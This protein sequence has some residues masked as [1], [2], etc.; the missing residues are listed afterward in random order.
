[1]KPLLALTVGD[2]AGVG[3]EIV[4]KALAEPEAREL[5]RYL[6][7]GP[8]QVVAAVHERLRSP[9][10]LSLVSGVEVLDFVPP[11]NIPVLSVSFEPASAFPVGKVSARSGKAAAEAVEHAVRLALEKKVAAIVT[12][13]LNKEA[14]QAA[15]YP[16]PG[17]T[18]MLGALCNAQASMLLWSPRL[19]VVHV[20][21]HCSLREAIERVTRENV[22]ATIQLAHEAMWRLGQDR[23]RIAVAGLNPHAG[24][25]GLFG[26][27]ERD[28]IRPAI[29]DARAD[30]L[31]VSG[32][33]PPD[34]VFLR[35]SRGEW[36]I[37]VGMYHDQGHIAVKLFGLEDGVNVTL[38]LP[39]IRTSV[40]HGTA[41]DIAG[42]GIAQHESML[43]AIRVAVTLTQGHSHG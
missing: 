22:R 4:L 36:D 6:V 37:V 25:S 35:A 1:M 8:H 15:G 9:F 29:E 26:T 7:I 17:H 41:F 39:I 24:E 38:G 21:V 16:Y 2:P 13:P 43:Q 27:E 40:D 42:Q 11:G 30:G 12:A 32:P 3:P 34:T 19:R 18:E 10:D 33:W 23:P 28:Q 31:D 5:A 20:S 14:L